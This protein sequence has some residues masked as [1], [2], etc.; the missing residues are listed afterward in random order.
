MSNRYKSEAIYTDK[1]ILSYQAIDTKLKIKL[2]RYKRNATIYLSVFLCTRIYHLHFV[3]LSF[4]PSQFA[5]RWRGL[6]Q[7]KD[8]PTK[9]APLP[10]P[11]PLPSTLSAVA[12]CP[13]GCLSESLALIRT[14]T[15][16][17]PQLRLH[18]ASQVPP[19]SYP[20]PSAPSIHS[21][22][23]YFSLYFL[24]LSLRISCWELNNTVRR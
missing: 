16:G 12:D 5:W 4:V 21:S 10:H 7:H 11:A 3:C 22:L 2:Q 6:P 18:S 8:H 24:H 23:L 9:R 14:F 20:Y 15:L 17:S 19:L 13:L 1:K